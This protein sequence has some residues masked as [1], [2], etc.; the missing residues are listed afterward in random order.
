MPLF[1]DLMCAPAKYPWPM[2]RAC[3][4]LPLVKCLICRMEAALLI[5][6]ELKVLAL[7]IW[8]RRKWAIT[9]VKF[10]K[11]QP[12][13]ATTIV[14]ILTSQVVLCWR[15]WRSSESAKVA[16]IR[17]SACLKIKTRT[18]IVR[19][20]S[21]IFIPYNSFEKTRT[22]VGSLHA[23]LVASTCTA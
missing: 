13:V 16:I 1:P 12:T 5:P 7:S 18:N 2:I 6:R 4:R 20:T 23:R 3:T 9:S 10:S 8:R 15:Q 22:C 17:T 19:A 14:R 11:H 21:H